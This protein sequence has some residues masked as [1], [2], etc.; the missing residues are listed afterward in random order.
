[1]TQQIQIIEKPDWV[2]WEDIKQCL[3]DAHSVN[4]AKGIN[5]PTDKLPTDKIREVVENKGVMLVALDGK[6]IVGTAAI[7]EKQSASW[8]VKGTYAYF[9]FASV[10]PKYSGQGLY[11]KLYQLREEIA[12]SKGYSV[13]VLNTHER[14]KSILHFAKKNG[15]RLVSCFREKREGHYNVVMAKWSMGC[16][17]SDIHCRGHFYYAYLRARLSALLH[18]KQKPRKF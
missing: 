18:N 1:M 3:V 2:S 9:G 10:I 7:I 6:K 17:Y 8:Y 4:R 11:K 16:P 13:F 5:M 15:Y 14:N 12:Q